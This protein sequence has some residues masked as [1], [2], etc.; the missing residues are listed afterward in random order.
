MSD[1]PMYS[2][3]EAEDRVLS[4]QEL[5]YFR[6]RLLEKRQ[7]ILQEAQSTIESD[8]VKLDTNE[9]KD[10][11]DI[12]SVQVQQEITFRLLDRSRKLLGEVERALQKIEAGDF[13]FCEGTGELISKKR[14]ELAPWARYSVE[15]KEA[16]ER[17]KYKIPKTRT[18][19]TLST[20]H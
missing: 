10:E 13:G 2:D 15:H 9:M 19:G 11:V 14:L 17:Q 18:D 5:K 8:K 16:L 6:D 7:E 4:E 1:R 12:A 3:V 20:V